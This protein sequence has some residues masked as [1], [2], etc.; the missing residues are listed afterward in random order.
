MI[1]LYGYPGWYGRG[2][3]WRIWTAAMVL[4]WESLS[5]Y[6]RAGPRDRCGKECR[7]TGRC[8]SPWITRR[9]PTG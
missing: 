5:W 7:C 9:S 3:G 4:F 1:A 6:V 2:P 8:W